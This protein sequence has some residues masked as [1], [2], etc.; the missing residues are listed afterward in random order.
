MRRKNDN[1]GLF[2]RVE[3]DNVRVKKTGSAFFA[4]FR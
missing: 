2:W 1:K 3:N 4:I